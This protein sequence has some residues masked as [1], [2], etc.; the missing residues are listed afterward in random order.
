MNCTNDV[1]EPSQY[2]MTAAADLPPSKTGI[3]A[4]LYEL[5][6]NGHQPSVPLLRNV[7]HSWQY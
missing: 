5:Q 3:F 4:Y 6:D 7:E 1:D 2:V